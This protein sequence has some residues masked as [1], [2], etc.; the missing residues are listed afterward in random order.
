MLVSRVADVA[1]CVDPA[2]QTMPLSC[3]LVPAA[4][5]R[6]TSVILHVISEKRLCL[7]NY[8]PMLLK[9]LDR[10]EFELVRS[11]GKSIF[12]CDDCLHLL[13]KFHVGFEFDWC[14]VQFCT[15]FTLFA[16]DSISPC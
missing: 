12:H 6:A 15:M 16:L 7:T 3:H 14:V 5:V 8:F 1:A 2:A 11:Q 4:A 13:P 9:D 10:R